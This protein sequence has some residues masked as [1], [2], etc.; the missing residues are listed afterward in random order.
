MAFS[1]HNR[2]T[3]EVTTQATDKHRI[4]IEVKMMRRDR[5]GDAFI[6]A[7]IRLPD[8]GHSLLSGDVLENDAQPGMTLTQRLQVPL[9]E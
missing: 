5:G 1:F 6:T 7:L 2:K 4:S 8:I 3:V 9:N